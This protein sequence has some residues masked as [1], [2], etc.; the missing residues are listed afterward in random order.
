MGI[1]LLNKTIKV[2]NPRITSFIEKP[3]SS[4]GCKIVFSNE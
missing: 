2:K 4:F 3:L 1:K